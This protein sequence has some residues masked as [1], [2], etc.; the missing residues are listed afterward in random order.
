MKAKGYH[1]IFVPAFLVVLLVLI[2]C[3]GYS[4]GDPGQRDDDFKKGVGS[5]E[6]SFAKNA[7]PHEVYQQQQSTAAIRIDNVGAENIKSGFITLSYDKAV[8][9]FTEKRAESFSIQGKSLAY[10]KG[11]TKILSFPFYVLPLATESQV[12]ETAIVASTCFD[13]RTEVLETVCIDMDPYDLKPDS[14]EEVC[15]QKD[16]SPGGTGGPVRVNKIE[17]QFITEQ[18]NVV[19]QFIIEVSQANAG[20]DKIYAP[21]NANTF[22]SGTQF[23]SD[24]NN[25][26]EFEVTLSDNKLTCN[27]EQIQLVD[28]KATITCKG[29]VIDGSI[30]NYEAP[31]Y[32]ELIYG[33][34]KSESYRFK[35]LR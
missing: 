18:G 16:L 20:R 17:T 12:R 28:G 33:V 26:V 23:D 25:I 15:Q 2:G 21:N 30:G 32:V 14:Q 11:D 8:L 6:L 9:D 5:L 19:P 27:R 7:P 34:S 29:F 10:P 1:S 24:K 35:V 22:C 4:E 31:L 13:Y 3:S